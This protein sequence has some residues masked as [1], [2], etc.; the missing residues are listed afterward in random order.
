MAHFYRSGVYEVVT[1]SST[2]LNHRCNT[3]T[4]IMYIQICV[5]ILEWMNVDVT[6]WK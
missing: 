2:S 1:I 5:N 4:I 3:T 6:Q